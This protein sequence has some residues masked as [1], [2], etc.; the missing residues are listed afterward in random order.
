MTF[1]DALALNNSRALQGRE[2]PNGFRCL[3]PNGTINNNAT[4]TMIPLWL[5]ENLQSFVNRLRAQ[6]EGGEWLKRERE[7]GGS[8]HVF[9]PF[10]MYLVPLPLHCAFQSA[11][12]K[13]SIVEGSRDE[14]EQ[15]VVCQLVCHKAW[16]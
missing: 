16:C 13:V 14:P 6:T 4:A 1:Q 5:R 10:A 2:T 15:L 12:L 11:F 9:L 7:G 3:S 8:L